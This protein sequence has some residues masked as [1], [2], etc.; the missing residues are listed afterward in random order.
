MKLGD[1]IAKVTNALGVAPCEPC[2]K[3]QEQLNALGTKVAQAVRG[4]APPPPPNFQ[5][6]EPETKP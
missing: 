6:A 1:A 4:K 3:R 5:D 2:K